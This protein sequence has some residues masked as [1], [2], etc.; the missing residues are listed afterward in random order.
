MT[1]QN[2]TDPPPSGFN[3]WN[4]WSNI[5][6]AERCPFIKFSILFLRGK[7]IRVMRPWCG[8]MTTVLNRCSGN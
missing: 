6:D 3:R 2:E 8:V 5:M 7:D 1:N 4:R